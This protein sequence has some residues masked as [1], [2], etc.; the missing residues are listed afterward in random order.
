M[1]AEHS[2]NTITT[3]KEAFGK[4]IAVLYATEILH[5]ATCELDRGHLTPKN[6]R[7]TSA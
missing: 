1:W 5:F 2:C 6:A 4:S 7:F 3:Y